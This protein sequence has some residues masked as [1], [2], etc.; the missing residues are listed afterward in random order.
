MEPFTGAVAAAADA[1]VATLMAPDPT[2]FALLVQNYAKR[3]TREFP[4]LDSVGTGVAA[5]RRLMEL[6]AVEPKLHRNRNKRRLATA[7]INSL[8]K[9]ADRPDA[10][11]WEEV[12]AFAGDLC[13]NLYAA[14]KSDVDF[15]LF[16]PSDLTSAS[17]IIAK[18]GQD[19]DLSNFVFLVRTLIQSAMTWEDMSG[20]AKKAR[21][22]MLL[23]EA[24]DLGGPTWKQ[25][26]L[27]AEPLLEQLVD[28]AKHRTAI[29]AAMAAT[30]VL[31]TTGCW[32]WRKTRPS[33]HA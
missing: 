29:V 14:A 1:E 30:T 33:K 26:Y 10:G 27:L 21:L 6:I 8:G 22:L 7:V 23:K 5:A 31:I 3:L 17:V 32:C 13:D 16:E 9:S 19:I 2:D 18:F 15:K 28:A 24:A 25:H 4:L 11:V 12:L 20:A